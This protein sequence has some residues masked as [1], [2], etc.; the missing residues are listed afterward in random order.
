[1]VTFPICHCETLAE[2][3]AGEG[4]GNL[5]AAH[6]QGDCRGSQLLN[7]APEPRNAILIV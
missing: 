7:P 5:V 6:W 4:R 3:S 2:V 1:M